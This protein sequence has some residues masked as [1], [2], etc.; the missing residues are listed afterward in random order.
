MGQ[1]EIFYFYVCNSSQEAGVDDEFTS[2]CHNKDFT[3]VVLKDMV[4]TGRAAGL[5]SFEIVKGVS[6]PPPS[7]AALFLIVSFLG[8]CLCSEE[9]TP[10]NELLTAAMKLKRIPLSE[11]Y[12]VEL[13]ATYQ[14]TQ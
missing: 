3:A 5:K 7:L 2:L 14:Q 11:K 1:S 12:K 13:D 9:W 6:I 4:A 8:V 10:E